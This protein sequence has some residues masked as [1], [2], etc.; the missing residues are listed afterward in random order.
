MET[1]TRSLVSD[2]QDDDNLELLDYGLGSLFDGNIDLSD[3]LEFDDE[4][5]LESGFDTLEDGDGAIDSSFSDGRAN[6]Q[7]LSLASLQASHEQGRPPSQLQDLTQT[8]NASLHFGDELTNVWAFHNHALALPRFGECARRAGR[9]LQ[10]RK[11]PGAPPE[12]VL[13]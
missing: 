3:Y 8:R 4:G 12:P 6:Q 1:A 10:R 7:R 9:F 11:L 5:N 13:C 2:T